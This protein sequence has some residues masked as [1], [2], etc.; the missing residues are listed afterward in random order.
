MAAGKILL[1]L[2]RYTGKVSENV[3]DITKQFNARNAYYQDM[4]G[5]DLAV[6]QFETPGGKIDFATTNDDGSITGQLNPAPEVPVNWL[7]L[8]GVNLSTKTDV[9]NITTD[10]IVRFDN[11]GKYIKIYYDG[12][13]ETP[14]SY[15]YL[16][17]KLSGS[18]NDAY[19]VS[20]SQGADVVYSDTNSA[21]SVSRLYY[22]SQLTFPVFGTAASGVNWNGLQLKT[23]GNIYAIS[24]DLAGG[25][26]ID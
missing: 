8:E 18:I 14:Y 22:D 12:V 2:S 20:L 23:G 6:I 25:I 16:L 21:G 9:N 26:V 13:A 15:A 11:P 3:I 19:N 4:S 5:W 7:P 10:A 1:R 17:S 24:I